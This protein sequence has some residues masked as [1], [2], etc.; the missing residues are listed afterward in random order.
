MGA[1]QKQWVSSGNVCRKAGTLSPTTTDL[2]SARNYT[3]DI[4]STNWHGQYPDFSFVCVLAKS[5]CNCSKSCYQAI[6]W[7]FVLYVHVAQIEGS[8][9]V[10]LFL[11]YPG[12]LLSV[13][14]ILL[15]MGKLNTVLFTIV[16]LLLSCFPCI[17]C[18]ILKMLRFNVLE[19]NQTSNWTSSR[20]Y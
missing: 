7:N 1:V 18:I 15:A 5:H 19:I 14:G 3:T 10:L 6:S 2:T 12:C 17:A 13:L 20:I 4:P 11:L 8:L 16:L 9:C